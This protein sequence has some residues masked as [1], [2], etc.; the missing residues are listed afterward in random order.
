MMRNLAEG[1]SHVAG[2]WDFRTP[3]MV[4]TGIGRMK[5]RR[6]G[7]REGA[8]NILC[9]DLSNGHVIAKG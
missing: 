1:Q 2:F 9:N 7:D 4:Q 8:G 5:G 3:R 6:P